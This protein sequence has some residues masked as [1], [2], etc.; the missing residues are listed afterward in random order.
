MV[1]CCW[2]LLGCRSGLLS[3]VVF[4]CVFGCRWLFGV[5]VC[6]WLLLFLCWLLLVDV[7]CYVLL[8]FVVVDRWLSWFVVCCCPC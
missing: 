3:R 1:C 8:V 5:C 4:V 6:S 2:S 7:V